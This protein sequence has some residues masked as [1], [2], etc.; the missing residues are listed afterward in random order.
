M[1]RSDS[2]RAVEIEVD[3]ADLRISHCRAWTADSR[4]AKG[5][6]CIWEGSAAVRLASRALGRAGVELHTS[7]GPGLSAAVYEGW[8]IR[9]VALEPFPVVGR[10]IAPEEYVATLRVERGDSGAATQ[11]G[12][13]P[14]MKKGRPCGRPGNQKFLFVR[15]RRSTALQDL[16]VVDVPAKRAAAAVGPD[17]E[18][19]PDVV[20]LAPRF[21]SGR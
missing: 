10:E 8:S 9:L 19:Q 17:V 7:P 15:W 14:A 3:G 20:L 18:A 12:R 13:L 16:Q 2:G 11:V 4:C 5:E 21:R 1:W 6:T